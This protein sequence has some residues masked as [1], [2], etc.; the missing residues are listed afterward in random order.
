MNDQSNT[1]II[2][3]I[4]ISYV[5]HLTSD[6]TIIIFISNSCA[7]IT[8]PVVAQHSV[9]GVFNFSDQHLIYLP[10]LDYLRMSQIAVVCKQPVRLDCDSDDVLRI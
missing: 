7:H 10:L 3:F 5:Y 6:T 8:Y 1:T 9:L 2:V 4:N